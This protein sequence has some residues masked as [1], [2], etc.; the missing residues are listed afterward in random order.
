MIFSITKTVMLFFLGLVG[1]VIAIKYTAGTST[2]ATQAAQPVALLAP[3]EVSAE[4]GKRLVI[5]GAC[6]DCHSPKLMTPE[7]PKVDSSRILSGH[8]ADA[9]VPE[10][11]PKALK[12]GSWILFAPDL[13][14]F[15]GPWGLSY[16]ANITSDSATGIGAWSEANFVNAI[17]TGKHM[18]MEGGRRISP[19]MP[20]DNYNNLTDAELKSIFAYL[21]TTKPISNRVHE[22]YS[23]EE[24]KELLKKKP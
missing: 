17:R 12:P 5:G 1:L 16:A 20:W 14:S 9:P 11:D 15:V 4:R 19:P 24:V 22:P 8:P 7:G 18:G 13:T 6:H 3:E 2:R 23:P 21:K 10:I